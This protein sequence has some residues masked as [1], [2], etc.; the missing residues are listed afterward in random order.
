MRVRVQAKDGALRVVRDARALGD[1]PLA[2]QPARAPAVQQ[3][4]AAQ[5]AA[6]V[7]ALDGP[8]GGRARRL[9][10]GDE[11]GTGSQADNLTP[12]ANGVGAE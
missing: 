8:T 4:V 9:E 2:A 11:L 12:S 7:K 5:H 10:R 3:R 6:G 1:A